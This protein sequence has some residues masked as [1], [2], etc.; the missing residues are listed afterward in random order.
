[1]QEHIIALSTKEQLGNDWRQQP[2][3]D[4]SKVNKGER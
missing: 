4:I 1:M 3:V 2:G